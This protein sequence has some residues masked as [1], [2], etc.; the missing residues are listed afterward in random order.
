ME[1]K[2]HGHRGWS[3]RTLADCCGAGSLPDVDEARRSYAAAMA[4]AD[5]LEM[6]PLRAH[7]L[8]GL[9]RLARRVGDADDAQRDLDDAARLFREMNARP[10]V[11]GDARG[12]T[13]G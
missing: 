3:L 1:Q 7:C 12:T 4:V 5:D 8:L 11:P 6:Q 9:G 13:A 10:I 2:E